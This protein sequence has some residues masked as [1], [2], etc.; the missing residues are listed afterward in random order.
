MNNL[1]LSFLAAIL[2]AGGF[3]VLSR[4]LRLEFPITNIFPLVPLFYAIV[5]ELLERRKVGKDKPVHPAKAR[6]RMKTGIAKILENITAGRI[7]TA[8]AVSLAIKIVFEIIFWFFIFNSEKN[9]LLI[10]MATSA[11]KPSANSLKAII[12]GFRETKGSIFCRYLQS[13]PA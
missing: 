6:K 2:V 8:I 11:S 5:Y 10:S 7:F 9:L 1:F 4:L 13:S 3:V 12:P